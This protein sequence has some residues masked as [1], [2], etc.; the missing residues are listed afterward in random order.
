MIVSYLF[1]NYTR[2]KYTMFV[3]FLYKEFKYSR[4]KWVFVTFLPLCQIFKQKTSI[5]MPDRQK[6]VFVWKY[7]ATWLFI[8]DKI[9]GSLTTPKL[10][11]RFPR[12]IKRRQSSS[13]YVVGS[14]RCFPIL[15]F[16]SQHGVIL[17]VMSLRMRPL[18]RERIVY[19]Q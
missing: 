4:I 11:C 16:N 10:V 9:F 6:N 15:S 7:V 18:T 1:S 12:S 2:W 13:F 3:H 17:C 19:G 5:Q 14:T 8:L